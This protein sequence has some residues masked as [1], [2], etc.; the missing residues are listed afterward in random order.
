MVNAITV[1]SEYKSLALLPDWQKKED[2]TVYELTYFTPELIWAYGDTIEVLQKNGIIEIP[3]EEK[4]GV[5]V[6]EEE[7]E[8]FQKTFKDFSIENITRYDMNAKGKEDRSHKLRLYRD[9]Y[10]V[11]RN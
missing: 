8:R 2:V 3:S 11:K 6:S 1:N 10:L 5:L 7:T 4:F 9:L